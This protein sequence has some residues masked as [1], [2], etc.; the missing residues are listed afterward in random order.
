MPADSKPAVFLA[1]EWVRTNAGSRPT[2][3]MGYGMDDAS[4]VVGRCSTDA[5][6]ELQRRREGVMP[7]GSS[8]LCSNFCG[9]G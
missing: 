4:G 5:G 1:Q 8:S 7:Y 2:F 3:D 6:Q 9:E